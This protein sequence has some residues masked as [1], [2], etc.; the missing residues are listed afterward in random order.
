MVYNYRDLGDDLSRCNRL[1]K[2]N[3]WKGK[4]C[5][6]KK[7]ESDFIFFDSHEGTEFVENNKILYINVVYDYHFISYYSFKTDYWACDI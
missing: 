7:S 5:L 1:K 6:R 2:A 3:T 4:G